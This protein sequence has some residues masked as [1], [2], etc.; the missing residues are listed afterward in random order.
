M[1]YTSIIF[2]AFFL[3]FTSYIIA[4]DLEELKKQ[5]SQD[6][7]DTTRL[8]LLI[9][10]SNECD[11]DEISFY[12]SKAVKL[13]DSLKSLKKYDDKYLLFK[14]ATAINNL[15]FL[16]HN[17]SQ[18]EKAKEAYELSLDI[19]E[20]IKDTNGIIMSYNN[21]SM[22]L[23]D[24]GKIDLTL[25][26]LDKAHYYSELINNI[27]MLHMTYTNYSAIYIR[28]GLIVKALEYSYKGLKIQEQ[29]GD[30]YGKGYA[31]N[32][33]G[34]LFYMQKDYENAKI[35]FY[36][37]LELRQKNNDQIGI[38]AVLNNLS[39]TYGQLGDKEKSEEYLFKCLEKRKEIKN[40]EGIAQSY[41]NIGEFYFDQGDFTKAKG[42]YD[43]AIDIRKKIG[44][45]EGLSNSYAN[46][47]TLLF[48]QGKYK[49]SE[50]YALM[51]FKISEDLGFT[52]DIEETSKV[53]SDIYEKIGDYRKAFDFYKL[54][55]EL[56]DS[57]FNQETQKSL[58]SKQINYEYE[59]KKLKDSLEFAREQE[60]KDLAIA[61]Q[62]AQLKQEK[63]QRLALY[64]GLFIIVIFS[65]FVYN[66]FRMSQNQKKIIELQ[67]VE[68]EQQK[69]VV[70][71]KNREIMDSIHYAKRIQ[72][73]ILPPDKSVKELLPNSFV[74][75]KPKDIVAGDFYWMESKDDVVLFAAADCT[76]HGVPGAMVSVVCN[77]GLNRSVREHGLT[78]PGEIL[79]KTR[80][81]VIAEFE[82]SEDDVKDGMDIALC[83]LK[84]EDRGWKL[85][86]AGANN[87][88]WLIRDDI[89]EIMEIKADKQPIGKFAEQKPYTTHTIELQKGDTIY[90]FSDGYADQF[91]G[92]KG[93][94]FKSANFKKL[95]LSIQPENMETQKQIINN[96]FEDWKGGIEQIDDVCVIGI[97]V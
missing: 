26:Y 33:I 23:K 31:L 59:K 71:E 66:R 92:E 27:D 18:Y 22:L 8:N 38:A 4:Q 97:R 7:H 63:T 46:M 83:S 2:V 41:S 93:K 73:A 29:I 61:K 11:Y 81:I 72:A 75:Y 57:L 58:L 51:S 13:A 88:L 53:L 85:Q 42:Y 67:K 9:D 86:Y 35:Y 25:E 84:Q 96:T 21:I 94:K 76:G 77:N 54:H 36:K 30:D 65:G 16:Y 69:E 39:K 87:P 45:A 55:N 70:E 52:N 82:K 78:V 28:T 49:E 60:I 37:S 90:V 12:A 62:E 40:P 1:R 47:S 14:K 17:G 15:A 20:Q 79:N 5:L 56:K 43:K 68:V 74:L 10:I 95:L 3:C 34:S 19:F 91:G 6:I 48:A 80:E 44:E 89:N 64:S 32:N 24:M 50:R